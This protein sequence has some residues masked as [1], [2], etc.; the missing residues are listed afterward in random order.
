MQTR[1]TISPIVESNKFHLATIKTVMTPNLGLKI[2]DILE[3]IELAFADEIAPSAGKTGRPFP[4]L[5]ATH[6]DQI[7]KA[8]P[9]H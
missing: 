2:G 4:S 6:D 7:G 1:S 5:Y 8:S 3:E 9:C